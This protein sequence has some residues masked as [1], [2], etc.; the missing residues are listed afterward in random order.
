MNNHF[1]LTT[2]EKSTQQDFLDEC[3][4]LVCEYR[5]DSSEEE[6]YAVTMG[7][8]AIPRSVRITSDNANQS[9]MSCQGSPD[10]VS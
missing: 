7:D 6:E 4:T 3:R 1:R 10:L 5:N 8:I 2:S 9:R